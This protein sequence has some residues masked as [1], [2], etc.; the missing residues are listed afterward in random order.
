MAD[1]DSDAVTAA[2]M[3]IEESIASTDRG[4]SV[5][6]TQ[7]R[8][9]LHALLSNLEALNSLSEPA[10]DARMEGSWVVH[11]TDAPPPSNGQFGIFRGIAKQVIDL[12]DK[13]YRNELYV[14]GGGSSTGPNN[15]GGDVQ[16]AWLT[17]V[18]DA[19]WNEWDGVYLDSADVEIQS[20]SLDNNERKYVGEDHGATTWKVD[21]VS[22]TLSIFHVPIFTQQFK[23]G[24]SRTWKMTYLDDDTRIVRAGKTGRGQ[25]DWIFYMKRG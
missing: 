14:G 23:K 17:A 21:F 11:Y 19:S 9:Q 16:G 25:D 8:A 24:T 18:L 15:D 22:L 2:K 13:R 7:R 4:R 12:K 5:E 6:S 10:R 3:Q 1:D 20:S